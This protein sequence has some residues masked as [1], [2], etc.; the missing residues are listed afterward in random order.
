V[1]YLLDT[2]H[3]TMLQRETGPAYVTLRARLVQ[4]PPEELAFSI[5]S[6]HEQ[7]MG[8]HTYINQARTAADLVRGYAMLTTVL[9]TFSRATAL[10]FDD[11]AAAVSATLVA[12]RVRL[13]R[14]DLRIAAIAL[15]RDLVVVTRNTRDFGRVPGLQTEDWTRCALLG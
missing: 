12:Q 1:T 11:A 4:H 2:D 13:R 7:V 8:C 14:M 15:A 6:L 5:I 9:R 10:P 3:I